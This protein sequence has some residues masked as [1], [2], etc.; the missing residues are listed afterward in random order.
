MGKRKTVTVRI[1]IKELLFDI[2]NETYL[3][4]RTVRDDENFRQAAYLFASEDDE[5]RDRLLRSVKSAW[6]EVRRELA[7]Y[8]D[9]SAASADNGPLSAAKDLVLT[10]AMPGNFNEAA[11][12]GIAESAHEFIKDRAVAD[13][14]TVTNINEAPSYAR[15]AAAALESVRL[16]AGS[17]RRPRRS[18]GGMDDDETCGCMDETD[19]RSCRCMAEEGG[20]S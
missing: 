17:R 12:A 9:E 13:W 3:R 8:L 1:S 15:L 18:C 6:S 14:Y 7:E 4:S 11:T 5:N 19:G 16:N 10:L 2:G 20:W